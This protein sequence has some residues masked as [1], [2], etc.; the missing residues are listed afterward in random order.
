MTLVIFVRDS[1]LVTDLLIKV[2]LKTSSELIMLVLQCL[3][4]TDM[5]LV[6]L[7][8]EFVLV[9]DLLRMSLLDLCTFLV[10]GVSVS[11]VRVALIVDFVVL[12]A[13]LGVMAFLVAT[14][15]C[16]MVIL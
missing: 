14:C 4:L 8:N 1:V 16:C 2:I 6:V 9:A 5:I 10:P 15:L 11:L 3:H 12:G 13:D 7:I